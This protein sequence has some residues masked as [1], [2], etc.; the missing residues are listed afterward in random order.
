MAYSV[1]RESIFGKTKNLNIKVS[2]ET[3]L[4]METER[5]TIRVEYT[6]VSSKRA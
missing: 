4:C 2:S 5:C 3:A 1:E 6:K